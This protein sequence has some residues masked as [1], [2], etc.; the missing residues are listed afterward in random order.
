VLIFAG[1]ITMEKAVEL[2]EKNFGQWKTDLVEGGI[3]LA[4][5]PKVE[6]TEIFVV[7]RPGSVQSDIRV[8]QFGFTRRAQPEYFISRVVCNYFGWSF[9][10]RLNESIRVKQG[11]TY[12]VWG[13]YYSQNMAGEFKISTFTKT[14]KTSEMVRAIIEQIEL[15]KEQP[16]SEKELTSSKNYLTG[17]FVRNRELPQQVADDLW[18]IESQKLGDDYLQRLL[19]QV[20]KT[21]KD[22]CDNLVDSTLDTDKLVITVV[23]DA[24]RIVADLEKIAPVTIAAAKE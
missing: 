9:N 3:V 19:A 4:D 5:F 20:K 11:L 21:T 15:L 10:S 7:D 18:L 13:G 8:G 16:P 12:A 24:E 17:S 1:D 6:K 2:A 14:E 23:G 22:D